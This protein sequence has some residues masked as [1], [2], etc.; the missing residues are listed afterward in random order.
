M[1]KRKEQT[2]QETKA[3]VKRAHKERQR[4]LKKRNKG[5]QQQPK[6]FREMQQFIYNDLHIRKQFF[7]T[8]KE[9]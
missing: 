4:E 7:T 2:G 1:G 9:T 6:W 8:E 5:T 3:R